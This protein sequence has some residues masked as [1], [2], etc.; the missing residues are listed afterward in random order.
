MVY[1]ISTQ[2]CSNIINSQIRHNQLYKNMKHKFTSPP[3]PFCLPSDEYIVTII[4]KEG[5]SRR[6]HSIQQIIP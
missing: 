3:F 4:K 6:T 5:M 2:Q 1:W